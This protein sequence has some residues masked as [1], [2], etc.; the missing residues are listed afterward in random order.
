MEKIVS[1]LVYVAFLF[2]LQH[3]NNYN[4][5]SSDITTGSLFQETSSRHP[6][7]LDFNPENNGMEE[8]NAYSKQKDLELTEGQYKGSLLINNF[9]GNVA[10]FYIFIAISEVISDLRNGYTPPEIVDRL[11]D[12]M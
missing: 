8:V 7:S 5:I 2:S 10:R 11:V 1:F 6:A 9:S 12:R 4:P 3:T